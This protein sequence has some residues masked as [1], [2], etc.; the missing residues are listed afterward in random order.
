MLFG[1][2]ADWWPA[3]GWSPNTLAHACVRDRQRRTDPRCYFGQG[4][5][6]GTFGL[7]AAG[8]FYRR[9]TEAK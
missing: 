8:C 2:D 7:H 3:P 6:E 9:E 4:P 5:R 1:D